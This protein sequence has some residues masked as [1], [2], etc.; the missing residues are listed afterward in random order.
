MLRLSRALLLSFSVLLLA[1]WPDV[2]IA[3]VELLW[4]VLQSLL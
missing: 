3:D 4:P 1:Q 2:R